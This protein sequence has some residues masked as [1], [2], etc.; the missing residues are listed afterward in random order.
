MEEKKK[1]DGGKV[2]IT[3]ILVL[4]TAAVFMSI[5]YFAGTNVNKETSD[6]ATPTT[7]TTAV[8]KKSASVTTTASATTTSATADWKAYTN[9]TYGFSFKYPV[10]LSTITDKIPESVST[11]NSPSKNLEISGT[12]KIITVWA[13]PAGFGLEGAND[14]Y[15]ASIS[16]GKIVVSKKDRNTEIADSD[17][18]AQ[19]VVGLMEYNGLSYMISYSYPS[20]SRTAS[21][22]EFD[23]ILSTFQFTSK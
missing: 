13:N 7:S 11:E 17:E 23:Q 16:G 3:S 1:F 20:D 9:K 15:T 12:G 10:S 19:A 14:F 2:I 4:V 18:T 21:L 22:V 8:A 6:L 5:G